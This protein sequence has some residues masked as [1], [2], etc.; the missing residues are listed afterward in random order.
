MSI[1]GIRT[2][3]HPTLMLGIAGLGPTPVGGTM[4]ANEPTVIRTDTNGYLITRPYNS[5]ASV[6]LYTLGALATTPVLTI[7]ASTTVGYTITSI[8]Y[9]IGGTV[10]VPN[11]YITMTAGTTLFSSYISAPNFQFNN[12]NIA[13]TTT[14]T[15][16]TGVALGAAEYISLFAL[17]YAVGS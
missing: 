8:G 15:I 4:G 2:E 16:T 7:P 10:S 1:E 5:F 12:L 11:Q 3:G 9:S 6:T 13:L 17:A 14:T